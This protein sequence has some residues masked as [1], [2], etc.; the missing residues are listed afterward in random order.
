MNKVR[1][2]CKICCYCSFTCYLWL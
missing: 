1:V 2:K